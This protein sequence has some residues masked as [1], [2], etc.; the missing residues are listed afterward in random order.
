MK[1]AVPGMSGLQ[2]L[3]P[4]NSV[5]PR[6]DMNARAGYSEGCMCDEVKAV[7]V[8][9]VS[10][11]GLDWFADSTGEQACGGISGK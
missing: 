1:S 2:G 3:G 8:C 9:H 5:L 11:E 6:L 7:V 4:P 10:R